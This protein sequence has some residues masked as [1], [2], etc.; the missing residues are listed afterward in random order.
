MILA[1]CLLSGGCFSHSRRGES[2]A[3]SAAKLAEDYIGVPYRYGGRDPQKGFDCS[4]LTW[5]VYQRQGLKLPQTSRD[6]L[7]AGRKVNKAKLSPGDLVFFRN[8]KSRRVDHVG[9]YVGQGRFVHAPG[10]G[11]KVERRDLSEK[12]YKSAYYSARRVAD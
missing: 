8:V 9:I 12:Y 4:G 6:Q 1:F 11:K 2:P 3:L 7:K 5:Y 10:A